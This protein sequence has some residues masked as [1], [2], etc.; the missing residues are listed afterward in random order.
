MED[1][2]SDGFEHYGDH[3]YSLVAAAFE[4]VAV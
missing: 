4:S 2:S 1:V 3:H